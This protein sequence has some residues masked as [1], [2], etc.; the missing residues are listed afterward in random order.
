MSTLAEFTASAQPLSAWQLFRRLA[1]GRLAP[2]RAWE[3]PRYRRKFMARSLASPFTTYDLLAS[4]ARQPM[5]ET[6]LHAQPGLPCR[7]HR[8]WLTPAFSRRDALSAI[9][10]HYARLAGS[11][12]PAAFAA[13]LS[14]QGAHL[15]T[16]AGKNEER[17]SISLAAVADL[18]KEGEAT[19]LF[20]NEQGVTLAELTFTLC[21]Y[22]GQTTI[23]IGGLQGAK[24]WV[25][26][27]FIQQATKACHGLFP[28]RL[29]LESVCQLAQKW[30]AAQIVAVGNRTHVYRSWRYEKK[31][32]EKLHA[33]Y[34]SFWL[35]LGAQQES[36]GYFRLPESIP[37][38]PMEEIASKKRA[39]YRRRY[40]LLDSLE[41]QLRD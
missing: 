9:T 24:A 38:K 6:L 7:L 28:K 41:A 37:R 18:D 36:A 21:Q 40:E 14:R 16:L 13:Y 32:K 35:S 30:G 29:L 33:D 39:E 17:Y 20:R 4:L 5:L 25:E 22:E 12:T 23:F 1:G 27:D 8:P 11:M 19:L 3:N 2:G 10:C 34:D 15:A 31:K 26:H